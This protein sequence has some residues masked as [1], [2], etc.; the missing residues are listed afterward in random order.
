MEQESV[1]RAEELQGWQRRHEEEVAEPQIV[2][3]VDRPV[4][5]KAHKESLAHSTRVHESRADSGKGGK[6]MFLMGLAGVGLVVA[7]ILGVFFVKR[8][9]AS[10]RG[11]EKARHILIHI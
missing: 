3:H 4:Q 6:G 10:R 5:S 8:K 1:V 2:Q 7:T 9:G 11:F